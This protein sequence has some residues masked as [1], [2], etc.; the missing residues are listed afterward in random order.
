MTKSK[1][2]KK[3]LLASVLSVVLCLSMLVGST[4]AWFTDTASTGVNKIVAGN[5]D[6]ELEYFD[7][8]DWKTVDPTQSLFKSADETLWEPGHTEYAILRVRNAGSLALKYDF[9]LD[10]YGSADGTVAEQQYT[11]RKGDKVYLSDYLVFNQIDG[12][13]AVTNRA[14]LWLPDE[15][16]RAAMGA[17]LDDI[18]GIS[19]ALMPGS[20]NEMVLAV[21]MPTFVGNE[22]N[23]L[24][25]A[26]A[27]EGD[28]TIFLGVTLNATQMVNENDSFGNDYDLNADGSPDYA[29]G[30]ITPAQVTVPVNPNGPT[31]LEDVDNGA[32][33]TVP[34][35]SA[36]DAD[37]D[38]TFSVKQNAAPSA[39][40][41]I[42]GSGLSF[43]VDVSNIKAGNT[44]VIETSFPVGIGLAI[45]ELYHGDVPMV[46][47]DTKAADTYQ[48]DSKTGMLTIY[49]THF[50][51]FVIDY[52]NVA[53]TAAKYLASMSA[54]LTSNTETTLLRDVEL[55][56]PI[57]NTRYGSRKTVWDLNG[58]TVKLSGYTAGNTTDKAAVL[59]L[60]GAIGAKLTIGGEGK[61]VADASTGC[62]AI[63]VNNYT[64]LNIT[65][66]TYVGHTTAV[67]ADKYS[68]VNIS[69]G[70]FAVNGGSGDFLLNR[71]DGTRA[72][73][74][75][76]GGT[77]VNF[78]PADNAADG[79]GTNYV[80]AGY[81]VVS[82]VQDNGDVWYT[83]V[84]E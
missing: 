7:G 6:V 2:I 67:Q 61:I 18:T 15:A 22:A 69:G 19:G 78:N 11:N 5:L 54:A 43:D 64:T 41:I 55:T 25:A 36:A 45:T 77:F 31:V 23:Q 14:E 75:V 58:K 79:A 53:K 37:K 62:Y 50:S 34:V 74:V 71:V 51:E 32:V 52:S 29:F 9:D 84:A 60:W 57:A 4:F 46:N 59:Y 39:P 17:E 33:A 16:A 38:M 24:T 3:A 42:T 73:I 40:G 1:S 49:V 10:V 65:G 21:Y 44:N 20:V 76:T 80:K 8:T 48:Y 68:T 26:K 56:A 13:T 70:F 35:G 81:T 27:T 82:E 12:K 83:V 47:A 30:S 72:K 63:A 28:P 66:G